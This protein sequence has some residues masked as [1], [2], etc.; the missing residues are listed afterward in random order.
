MDIVKGKDTK[1]NLRSALVEGVEKSGKTSFLATCPRPILDFDAER[2][3]ESRLAGLDYVD[4]VKCY[5]KAGEMVGAGFRRF[6]KNL[7]E[8]LT[9]KTI[10]YKT[11]AVDPI[12]F[13]SDMICA[14]LE[15]TNP[16][17]K[18]S[19]NT[20]SFWLKTKDRHIELV[21]RLLSLTSLGIFIL[22]TSHVK[23]VEDETTGTKCF[24]P[25]INGSFRESLGTKVDA[26]FFTK[27]TPIGQKVK[28]SLQTLP[29]SQ[30]KAGIRVPLGQEHTIG[31]E[32]EPDYEK[33]LARL[34]GK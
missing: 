16:G 6:E 22:F 25:D 32:V 30:K 31:M 1:Y 4:V 3:G 13:I 34:R 17:L 29:S 24:L 11:I 26:V 21:D 28:Y 8:L 7:K 23:L 15:R 10:P 20:F 19:S 27:T 18:G 2:S 5:D 12:S 14:E 9:M 33:L